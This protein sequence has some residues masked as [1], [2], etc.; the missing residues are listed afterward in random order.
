MFLLEKWLTNLVFNQPQKI[1]RTHQRTCIYTCVYHG[2]R[3]KRE[4][5]ERG[6]DDGRKGK[7]NTYTYTY[8]W[9]QRG[10]L[11]WNLCLETF[12]WVFELNH[13]HQAFHQLYLYL[14]SFH[15]FFPFPLGKPVHLPVQTIRPKK[16]KI[17][18]L[19]HMNNLNQKSRI[20]KKKKYQK[21]G[22]SSSQGNNISTRNNSRTSS[23]KLCLGI[24]NYIKTTDTL[25][26]KC[27]FFITGWST[28]Y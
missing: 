25:M 16:R 2:K 7:Q 11:V 19:S 6:D 17:K 23:F 14:K 13:Q 1:R 10:L 21:K 26:S 15:L 18:F 3:E 8:R 28:V 5:R 27:I 24:L 20:K 4:E 9:E 22:I 12:V